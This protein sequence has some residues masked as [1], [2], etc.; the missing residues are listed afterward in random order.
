[1]KS[2]S[3]NNFFMNFASGS[4]FDIIMALKEGPMSVSEIAEKVNG[5]QSA[6]SHNLSKLSKCH[7]LDV[8]KVGKKRVYSLN[9]ETVIPI[10][11]T[12]EEHVRRHCLKR[13][14]K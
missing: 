1:M 12:V 5:E 10:L 9:M 13:C 11:R 4:K 7:I 3:Y 6:V 14:C 8:K 2:K